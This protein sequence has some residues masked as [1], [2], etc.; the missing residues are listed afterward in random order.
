VGNLLAK[1]AGII[2]FAFIRDLPLEFFYLDNIGAFFGGYAV[3][4][5]GVYS[6]ITNVTR[7]LYYKTFF[8]R[9]LRIFVIS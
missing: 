8:G 9:N 4:Y 5:L 7:G 1:A 3:Y 6:Y 2:N